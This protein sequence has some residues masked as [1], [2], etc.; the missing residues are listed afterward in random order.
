MWIECS[1]VHS[2]ERLSRWKKRDVFSLS[3]DI[4]TLYCKC[5]IFSQKYFYFWP[6]TDNDSFHYIF[7]FM[8][9]FIKRMWLFFRAFLWR[10]CTGVFTSWIYWNLLQVHKSAMN[11]CAPLLLCKLSPVDEY[12]YIPTEQRWSS[13]SSSSNKKYDIYKNKI[14]THKTKKD[15]GIRSFVSL[16]QLC[17]LHFKQRKNANEMPTWY[18]KQC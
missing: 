10:K 12:F 6:I 14:N 15:N 16:G 11:V 9:K 5:M 18:I 17:Y 2:R 3:S 7:F 13:S 1:T 4:H 8:Q